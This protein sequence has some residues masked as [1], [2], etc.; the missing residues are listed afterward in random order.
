MKIGIGIDGVHRYGGTT[1]STWELAEYM[2]KDHEVIMIT[3]A[4]E[5]TGSEPFRCHVL[6]IWPNIPYL[7]KFL[8][9][10]QVSRSKKLLGLDILN[11][12]GTN[13]L[14]QDVVTAQSVHKKWFKWSLG[15]TKRFSKQ[16]WMKILN[17]VHYVII[18]IET[19]QYSCGLQRKVIAI[20]EQVKRDLLNEFRLQPSQIVVVHHGVNTKEFAPSEMDVISKLEK[21][22]ELDLADDDFVIIF[23]AH[24]FRRKGLGVLLEAMHT[25]QDKHLKLLVVGQ[26]DPS[27]FRRE[28]NRLGLDGQILF[29]GRQ[30]QMASLYA[31]S[32]VFALPT[33]YEAFGMVITEA[34]AAGL[35]VIVPRDAGAAELITHGK[36]GMLMDRWDDA[37]QL[38]DLIKELKNPNLR[39]TVA[40]NARARAEA[41][42]WDDA[43]RSTLKVFQEVQS[44]A[45]K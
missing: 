23:A 34:M 32:D 21:R 22:R 31:A 38:A 19:L 33:S 8:F 27:M 28:A 16:W 30:M 26:D 11:V 18:A 24:E 35:P 15:A 10:W 20:S 42:T 29:L 43:A 4:A 41:Y 25:L 14:W 44:D 12:H 37:E 5:V 17:P 7:E 1:R 13:G 39:S 40:K 36:D 3:K 6:K 2:A 9:A 45:R